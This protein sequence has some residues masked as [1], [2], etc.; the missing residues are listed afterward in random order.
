MDVERASA[1]I[2]YALWVVRMGEK[3]KKKESPVEVRI[4][5]RAMTSGRVSAE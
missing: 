1:K 4:T 3:K 2:V 5:V